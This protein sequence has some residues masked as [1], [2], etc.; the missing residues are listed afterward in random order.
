MF[1]IPAKAGRSAKARRT[2]EGRPQRGERSESSSDLLVIKD[3]D[4]SF[5]WDDGSVALNFL[6]IADSQAAHAYFRLF[7]TGFTYST[8]LWS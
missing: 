2:S 6:E 5:R 4:P 1:V 3:M 8:R 7:P